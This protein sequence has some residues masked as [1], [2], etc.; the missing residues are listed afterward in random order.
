[1]ASLPEVAAD[2]AEDTAVL[3]A[4]AALVL[5]HSHGPSGLSELRG[6]YV[7]TFWADKMCQIHS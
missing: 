5:H 3:P 6:W 4:G 2:S 1:M 7:D